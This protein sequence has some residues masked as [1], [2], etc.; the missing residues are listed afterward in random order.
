MIKTEQTIRDS[1]DVIVDNWNRVRLKDLIH[2]TET[3]CQS[4]DTMLEFFES[5]EEYEKCMK[6]V[7]IKNDVR[8][9]YLKQK[10][11]REAL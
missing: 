2:E 8:G 4:I 6:L 1:Y 3:I 7:Y 11:L 9:E 10:L 5:T